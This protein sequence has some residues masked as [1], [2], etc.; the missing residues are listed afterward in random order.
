MTRTRQTWPLGPALAVALFAVPAVQGQI[1][2]PPPRGGNPTEGGPY[3]SLQ[4]SL[5]TNLPGSYCH[6]ESAGDPVG[7]ADVAVPYMDNAAR[8]WGC[9]WNVGGMVPTSL[10]GGNWSKWYGSESGSQACGLAYWNHARQ[11]AYFLPGSDRGTNVAAASQGA[12]VTASSTFNA[13]TPAGSL[14]DGNRRGNP[15]GSGGGWSSLYNPT[16]LSPQAIVVNLNRSRTINEVVVTTL[17]DNYGA[18]VEPTTATTFTTYGIRNFTV[19]A[20]SGISWV[21]VAS[22]VGNNRVLRRLQF[23]PVT[24]TRLRVS[25]TAALQNYAR[26][27]EV[28]AYD[29]SSTSARL[30]ERYESLRYHA[31]DLGYP[32]SNPTPYGSTGA[33]YQQFTNGIITY[34]SGQP[35]AFHLGGAAAEDRALAQRYSSVFGVTPK[36]GPA[37]YGLSHDVECTSLE[38]T[39]CDEGRT[40]RYAE[41][42]DSRQGLAEMVIARTG[43]TTAVHVTGPIRRRWTDRYGADAPWNTELG[44]PLTDLQPTGSATY[45]QEF[46]GGSILWEPSGCTS[47]DYQARVVSQFRRPIAGDNLTMLCDRTETSNRT[48]SLP[49]GGV[50][51]EADGSRGVYRFNSSDESGWFTGASVR[52]NGGSTFNVD[53]PLYSAWLGGATGGAAV[54]DA[55]AGGAAG[56]GQPT[57]DATCVDNPCTVMLQPFS[58]G[59]ATVHTSGIVGWAPTGVDLPVGFGAYDRGYTTTVPANPGPQTH[60]THRSGDFIFLA[61]LNK[62]TAPD[63]TT[64]IFRTMKPLNGAWTPYAAIKT[65]PPPTLPAGTFS[66]FTDSTPLNNATICYYLRVSDGFNTE[67]TYPFCTHTLD[68]TTDVYGN[69]HSAPRS[70]NRARLFIKVPDSPDDSATLG[71]VEARLDSFKGGF[72]FNQTYLDSTSPTPDFALGSGRLYDL[73]LTGID[74]VADIVGITITSDHRRVHGDI[75]NDNL[76]IS[77]VQLVLDDVLVFNKS[78]DPPQLVSN[79]SA[80][81]GTSLRV[82]FEELRSYALW[83]EFYRA[84]QFQGFTA[85]AFT[86]KL[87]S[88]LAHAVF[89]ASGA[90]YHGSKLRDGFATT[91]SKPSGFLTDRLHVRQ[92]ITADSADAIFC[93]IDY[94]LR[95]TARDANG[96]VI[97][98]FDNPGGI[99][100]STE[101]GVEHPDVDCGSTFMRDIIYTIFSTSQFYPAAMD[102]LNDDLEATLRGQ[103]PSQIQ[104]AP[105][106]GLRF[107]FPDS[108][109]FAKGLSVCAG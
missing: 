22:V 99:I 52:L 10:G 90:A 20:W 79:S 28:E 70:V 40:G 83:K 69:D 16:A 1:I 31:G 27:V 77:Q 3:G 109:P 21:Q 19:E 104:T 62:A 108:G 48:R 61:W 18:P 91:L 46:E 43:W 30:L 95:I 94:D 67:E 11:A 89:T 105:P 23:T 49:T 32:V 36:E 34:V 4:T 102:R 13:G 45:H 24:T 29:A 51:F 26:V 100:R 72:E 6:S 80:P 68:G 25:I 78:Y 44:F 96:N 85:A 71:P 35:S 39:G 2:Q 103:A 42:L 73:Q 63:V 15:W 5:C 53:G 98:P 92:H 41:W 65:Y 66:D 47:G 14:I 87:D 88:I 55:L 106:P 12:T 86:S 64:T 9:N 81:G 60:I 76:R 101:I 56:W 97:S 82:E 8:N 107:C 59:L 17:Q 33:T 38:G 37:V 50:P 7:T 54:A 58:H 57:G 75:H 84:P 74:D 93:S